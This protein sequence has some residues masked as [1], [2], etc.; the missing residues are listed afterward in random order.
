MEDQ[1][2]HSQEI[3]PNCCS[4][5]QPYATYCAYCGQK[6]EH[7]RPTIGQLLRDF[8]DTVFNLDNRLWRTF[9]ALLRPGRLTREFFAGRRRR[10]AHPLRLFFILGIINFAFFGLLI[11][12]GLEQAAHKFESNSL[13]A[14]YRSLFL[15]EM[16]T[17][18]DSL[19]QRWPSGEQPVLQAYRDSILV[20]IRHSIGDTLSL[21]QLNFRIMDL[22]GVDESVRFAWKDVLNLSPDELLDQYGHDGFWERLIIRQTLR[23]NMEG[24]NLINFVLGN[25]LWMVVL[26]MPVL[27]M[28]LKLLYIR[29]RYFVVEHLIFSF[30]FHAFIFLLLIL[31]YIPFYFYS[32]SPFTK[33]TT[34]WAWLIIAGYLLLAMKSVYRQGWIKTTLKWIILMVQ[35]FIVLT[36]FVGLTFLVS[37]LTF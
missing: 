32:E 23:L 36:V 16:I 9:P 19:L 15:Q 18:S 10:Y 24:S 13:E 30:H 5:L 20:E 29:R 3:C 34:N 6:Q 31:C 33:Q 1:P 12:E 37:A 21:S 11:R 22:G 35:Y 7:L 28:L 25:L 8:F 4:P 2:A 17:E 26:M 14:G 27:A